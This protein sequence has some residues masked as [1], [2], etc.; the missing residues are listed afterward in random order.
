MDKNSI[1]KDSEFLSDIYNQFSPDR[2]LPANDPV[3]VDCSSVRGNDDIIRELGRK[4]I[5][6]NKP[7]YQLYTGHRGGGKS[8]EI[9]R[10][11]Y[12]LKKEGCRVVYFE[13]DE[14]LDLGDVGYPDILLACTRH[15]VEE[16]NEQEEANFLYKWIGEKFKEILDL[17]SSELELQEIGIE[18]QMSPFA[19]ITSTLQV[20][21]SKRQEIR[22]QIESNQVSFAKIINQF[23]AQIKDKL[24]INNQ[25]KLVIIADNL[26]RIPTVRNQDGSSNHEEIFIDCS[27][28][29]KSLI[30][31]V[32]YT[33]PISL[34]Y[35]NRSAILRERYGDTEV[36]PMIMV[37]DKKG[38]RDPKGIERI[39]KVIE[40]R[41]N[42]VVASFIANNP[43]INQ[44]INI[45][46]NDLF[47]SPESI[48]LLCSMTGGHAREI[49]LLVQSA[50]DWIET[51]P[52]TR[53]AINKAIATSRNTYEQQVNH[54]DWP[55]LVEVFKRKKII[56]K[57]EYRQLLYSRCI[58]EYRD[59]DD[60][61]VWH[62]VHP[63]IENIQ[64]FKD[65]ISQDNGS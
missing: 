19:K 38:N 21:P 10:L 8:T 55:K 45:T 41:I 25:T 52:I 31:H 9:L 56:N 1:I 54:E 27:S 17:G 30:C 11:E 5:R 20:V 7:T 4:I 14:D 22:K 42:F 16:L 3:Y 36:L 61:Q 18:H 35:S 64:Q 51:F 32:I 28:Q 12:Y 34:V 44:P 47:D 40:Q 59:P 37:R 15:L 24:K 63:L 26:D 43:N 62:D 58:L 29:L 33:V 6:S 57:D 2:P 39:K 60:L 49:M 50:M 53:N 23:I 13:A 48:D 65:A 46:I